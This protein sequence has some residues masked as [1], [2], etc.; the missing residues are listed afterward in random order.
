[1]RLQHLS[2]VRQKLRAIKLP[3]PPGVFE[4]RLIGP[5]K[6]YNDV[7]GESVPGKLKPSFL[8]SHVYAC[9]PEHT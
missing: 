8:I 2:N 9:Q 6:L 4:F 3:L 1:M 5:A 7:S